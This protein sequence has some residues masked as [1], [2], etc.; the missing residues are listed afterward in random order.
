MV[1]EVD[2]KESAK[3]KIL[4]TA[5]E[6]FA[7]KGFDGARVDEIARRAGV[8]KALIYYYYKNKQA[9]LDALIEQVK[10][11]FSRQRTIVVEDTGYDS[12]EFVDRLIDINLEY[13]LANRDLLSIVFMEDIK[14]GKENVLMRIW[15]EIYRREKQE[16]SR[17][18]G[19][20]IPGPACMKWSPCISI[21]SCRLFHFLFLGIASLRPS[22]FQRK[23][24]IPGIGVLPSAL[25]MMS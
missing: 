2:D 23:A 14:N 12:P 6:L 5:K 21:I 4:D 18:R 11:G 3:S 17:E 16:L 13:L 7:E 15:E 1:S 19:R 9:L 8:N 22:A 25:W 20:E 10:T 24:W